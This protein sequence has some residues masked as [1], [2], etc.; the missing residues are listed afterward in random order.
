M[1][2]ISK[3]KFLA[4]GFFQD[5]LSLMTRVVICLVMGVGSS[6]IEIAMSAPG[7]T[8]TVVQSPP[9]SGAWP[10][11]SDYQNFSCGGQ[12]VYDGVNDTSGASNDRDIV[13]NATYPAAKFKT[14]T[15]FLFIRLRL[16]E[17]PIQTSGQST[18]LTAFGWGIA[19]D[20]NNNRNNYEYAA[21]ANGVTDMFQLYTY[22]GDGVNP[23]ATP[24]REAEFN[25]GTSTAWIKVSTADSTFNSDPDYYLDVAVPLTDL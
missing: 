9:T 23:S 10:L 15:S 21:I 5:W 2:S 4:L 16:D 17:D 24:L 13:G 25:I 14:T 7:S 22:T 20:T 11:S 6:P 8:P 12:T 18:G 3:T 19:F 1:S